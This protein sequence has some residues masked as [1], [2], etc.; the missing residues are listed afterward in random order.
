MNERERER[1]RKL[2]MLLIVTEFRTQ[3]HSLNEEY[4]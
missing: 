3:D 2:P 1:E 4:Y